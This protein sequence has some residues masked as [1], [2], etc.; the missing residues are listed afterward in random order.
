MK[1]NLM[2]FTICVCSFSYVLTAAERKA[3]FELADPAYVISFPKDHG[4]HKNFRIEWWYFTANLKTKSM[5]HLGIQWTL[6]KNNLKPNL[7]KKLSHLNGFWMAHA[8]ITTKNE[9][10]FDERF[11]REGNMQAGVSLDPFRAWIDNWSV[12]GDNN[13]EDIILESSGTDFSMSLRFSTEYKPVLQGDKGYSRKSD[14]GAASH[15]YSQPFYK[16]K[17]WVIFD[18]EKHIVE[19]FGWLD[20]EWSSSLLNENQVGW[21]WFSLHLDDGYKVMLFRV[22]DKTG[23]DFVS[24]SWI[25]KDGT[26]RTLSEKDIKFVE[27]AYTSVNGKKIPTRWE[28]SLTLDYTFSITATA[29]NTKSW[30]DTSFAYWEGPIIINDDFVGVGYLEMTGY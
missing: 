17:G 22:R 6:F 29:L 12:E 24:G 20:R 5:E 8:A 28:I 2:L 11:A 14:R 16:V 1:F 10:Y 7:N 4:A 26:K 15:Y 9:H 27:K 21:D 13:L 18:G 25:L 30:M 19:G 3:S 23:K